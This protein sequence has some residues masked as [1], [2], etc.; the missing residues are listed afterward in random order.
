MGASPTQVFTMI[1]LDQLECIHHHHDQEELSL[2][3]SFQDS[4]PKEE[5]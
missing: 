5:Q 4:P 1:T 2:I 3:S